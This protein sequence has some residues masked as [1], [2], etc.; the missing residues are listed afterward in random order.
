MPGRYEGTI[1]P[2]SERKV[3]L[4]NL[5][6]KLS[7][8]Y[9]RRI[10]ERLKLKE[11]SE[12]PS[13]YFPTLGVEVETFDIQH[14]NKEF[15]YDEIAMVE[16]A[17]IK[18]DVEDSFPT[19]NKQHKWEVAF[20][21]VWGTSVLL[22]REAQQ[23]IHR[24]IIRLVPRVS[25]ADGRDH[26]LSRHC[27][28]HITLGRIKRDFPPDRYR[29]DCII[30]E[31]DQVDK[32]DMHTPLSDWTEFDIEEFKDGGWRRKYAYSDCFLFARLFDCTLFTTSPERII[33]PVYK[34]KKA[35]RFKGPLEKGYSGVKA[36][37]PLDEHGM[38]AIEIRTCELFGERAFEGLARYL[39]S[40]ESIGALLISYQ[41]LPM[42]LRDRIIE[43]DLDGK[44]KKAEKIIDTFKGF[45]LEHDR[46]F[47]KH[48]LMLRREFVQVCLKYGVPNPWSEYWSDEFKTFA[49][50]LKREEKK[51]ENHEDNLITDTRKLL[52]KYRAYVSDKLDQ[53]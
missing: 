28:V 4:A 21:P 34:L 53:K 27:P 16:E 29:R 7:A 30:F 11:K 1:K 17:G 23:L 20:E 31:G 33:S 38:P 37:E 46:E 51:L 3:T 35:N 26:S 15:P 19:K 8:E 32:Y 36:R 14:P 39:K 45:D 44:H 43:S 42:E 40:A 9:A 25:F 22:M 2:Y 41:K 6:S 47:A 52:V 18:K 12:N 50:V 24:G 13:A 10:H 5:L 49:N 48:W